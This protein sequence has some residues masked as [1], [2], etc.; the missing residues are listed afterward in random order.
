MKNSSILNKT[1]TEVCEY[2]LKNASFLQLV[3]WNKNYDF[4][5]C[6]LNMFFHCK[7]TKTLYYLFDVELNFTKSV[8]KLFVNLN[9]PPLNQEKVSDYSALGKDC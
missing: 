9:D 6:Y 7:A 3:L 1:E 8:S 2:I 4:E 5:F